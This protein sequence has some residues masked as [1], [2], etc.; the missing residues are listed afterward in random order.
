[1]YAEEMIH[2]AFACREVKGE[3][4]MGV[5][6]AK[7][8]GDLRVSITNTNGELITTDAAKEY[9]GKGEA[10][11]PVDLLVVSLGACAMTVMSFAA[12]K[13]GIDLKGSRVE[14]EWE[15]VPGPEHRIDTITMRFFISVNV[16]APR[17]KSLETI[18]VNCP[19]HKN[20][21]PEIKEKVSFQY[22]S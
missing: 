5:F 4:I 17:R 14:L 6:I 7:N 9:G 20:L 13:Q 11:G 12:K 1:V 10:L 21:N 18:A 16:D 3:A 8:E 2:G 22:A 19:V 15:V